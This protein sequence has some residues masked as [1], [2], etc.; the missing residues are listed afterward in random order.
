MKDKFKAKDMLLKILIYSIISILLAM[1][2]INFQKLNAKNLLETLDSSFNKTGYLTSYIIEDG[3]AI[4]K[5]IALNNENNIIVIGAAGKPQTTKHFAVI[6]KF[7]LNGNPIQYFG[8]SKGY[9]II[10]K[11][12]QNIG[13][14]YIKTVCLTKD[15]KILV[16]GRV[17]VSENLELGGSAY[18]SIFKFNPDGSYDKS[19]ANNGFLLLNIENNQIQRIPQINSIKLDSNEKIIAV[20]NVFT[21]NKN[22][23]DIIILRI[24]P[25][26]SLD[27]TF[28][29]KGYITLN[30]FE[31]I[32]MDDIANSVAVDNKN[33]RI[34]IT[35]YS[36][37]INAN[38]MVICCLK[39]DGTLDKTFGY[40]GIATFN[41]DSVN[42]GDYGNSIIVDNQD[43]ILVAG[44]TR[45]KRG[46]YDIIIWRYNPNG[47]LDK[48]FNNKGYVIYDYKNKDDKAYSIAIDNQNRILVAGY[49]N[50]NRDDDVILL[51]Y[52]ENGSLDKSFANKGVFVYNDIA[53]GDEKDR[54]Y[55]LAIDKSQK[56]Y[57]T[58][59]SFYGLYNDMFILKIN[60]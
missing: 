32:D 48:S 11:I 24:N 45:S 23:K 47:T 19:F 28:N 30:A 3:Y 20:G 31:Q 60:P 58:G 4:A 16:G 35:G 51:R 40:N 21:K 33:N 14:P 46:D 59:E 18:G 10:D 13:L 6:W 26:G 27:K 25:D 9:I 41:N 43:R 2:I 42:M 17:A 52:N 1:L 29:N 44:Y 53:G 54:A 57:L 49:V 7:D 38:D 55:S 36:R 8:N 15:N 12:S 5:D 50:N 39:S 56:I 34:Y 22:N 37:G